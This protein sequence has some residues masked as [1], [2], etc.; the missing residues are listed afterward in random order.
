[1]MFPIKKIVLFFKEICTPEN[2]VAG[3]T[4]GI[5]SFIYL[6]GNISANNVET[7]T[8]LSVGFVFLAFFFSWLK[9]VFIYL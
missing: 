5:I 2:I 9:R 6:I 3:G 7:S 1:M 8:T 4:V